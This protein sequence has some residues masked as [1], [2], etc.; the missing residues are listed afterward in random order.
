VLVYG[1][2]GNGSFNVPAV[3]LPGGPFASPSAL[4]A[5]NYDPTNGPNPDLAVL[6]FASNRIDLIHNDSVPG[7]L[8]FSVAPTTPVSPWANVSATSI[9][10]ADASV[11][12]DLV[13]L[14]SSPPRLD[15]L[16]G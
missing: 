5:L 8:S 7:S 15:V 12:Q 13:M 11:G 9:F 10:A 3:V 2:A 14:V 1:G 6:G 4:A 16:S